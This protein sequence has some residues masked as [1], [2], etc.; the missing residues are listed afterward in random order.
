M[1]DQPQGTSADRPPKHTGGESPFPFF[2]ELSDR[3]DQM[4]K[5][6]ANL[7]DLAHAPHL[8]EALQ[9]WLR[10]ITA[11]AARRRGQM[12][13]AIELMAACT[14]PGLVQLW[15]NWAARCATRPADTKA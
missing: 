8:T 9:N 7:R 4:M 14:N 2:A 6:Q 5:P 11:D 1:G 13:L 15:A 3:M 12:D 10:V